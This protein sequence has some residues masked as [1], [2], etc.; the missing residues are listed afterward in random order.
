MKKFLMILAVGMFVFACPSVYSS[1]DE[2]QGIKSQ[3]T[4]LIYK[5][6]YQEA[7]KL[8]NVGVQK[9][10]NEAELYISRAIAKDGLNQQRSALTDLDSAIKL[11]PKSADSYYW[12]GVVK[13]HL[14]SPQGAYQDA[15]TC[16]RLDPN[17]SDCYALRGLVRM[18]LNDPGSQADID[19]ATKLMKKE[20][21][22]LDKELQQ[23]EKEL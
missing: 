5:E 15:T 3:S 14:N 23:L 18:R 11:N 17:S 7:L 9:Y 4:D 13:Y 22:E 2:L 1:T 10:P 19:K 8:L 21:A 20:N 12:R 6:K 16:L